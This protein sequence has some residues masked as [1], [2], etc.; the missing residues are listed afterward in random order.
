[1]VTHIVNNPQGEYEVDIDDA[2]NP[3]AIRTRIHRSATKVHTRKLWERNGKPMSITARCAW[4]AYRRK[5]ADGGFVKPEPV[6]TPID[7]ARI[8]ELN[9]PRP[10]R[11]QDKAR[12]EP[13]IDE[14]RVD[15]REVIKDQS[16]LALFYAEDGAY[17]SAARILQELADR[18]KAHAQANTERMAKALG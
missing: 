2:G 4:N 13:L 3:L 15:M 5:V 11:E 17:H 14:P 16:G 12:N 10:L 7:D 18:V 9:D 1:M 8:R 6:A